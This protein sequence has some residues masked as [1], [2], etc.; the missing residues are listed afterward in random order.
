[1]LVPVPP[2]IEEAEPVAHGIVVP[3]VVVPYVPKC[4]VA[5]TQAWG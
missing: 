1:M 3:G 5:G 4:W 2:V